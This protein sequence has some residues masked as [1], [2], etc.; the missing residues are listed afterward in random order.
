MT[1]RTARPRAYAPDPDTPG[2]TCD[3]PGCTAT[4]DYRAPK[5]RTSLNEYWWFCLEHVRAYNLSLGFLQ[6]HEPRA[7]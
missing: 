6:G 3:M 1:R 2:R 7:D 4:G 5:S